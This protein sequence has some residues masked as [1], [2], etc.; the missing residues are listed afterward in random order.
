MSI[1]DLNKV[2]PRCKGFTLEEDDSTDCTTCLGYGDLGQ[3]V[4]ANLERTIRNG[5]KHEDII[6]QIVAQYFIN[7]E[8]TDN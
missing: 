3:G 2:C 5:G 6:M 8:N 4:I 1:I 7:K